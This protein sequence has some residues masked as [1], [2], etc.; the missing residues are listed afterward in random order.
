MYKRQPQSP[1]FSLEWCEKDGP[2][3]A[4]PTRFGFGQTVITR[5]LQYSVDGG[6]ELEYPSDGV[7]C[8]MRIPRA[9]VVA[10]A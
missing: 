7:R 9:D 1:F 3:V 6:A 8:T 4:K 2:T 5:S 10:N